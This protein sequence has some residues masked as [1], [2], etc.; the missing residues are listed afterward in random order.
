[1]NQTG[2][3]QISGLAAGATEKRR[4]GELARGVSSVR[5][6]RDDIILRPGK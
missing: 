1:M 6:V 4:A 3:V 5:D 2:M